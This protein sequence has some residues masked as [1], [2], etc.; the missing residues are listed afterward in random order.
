MGRVGA[1]HGIRGAFRVRPE[2]ADPAALL[3]YAEWLLRLRGGGW[4]PRRVRGARAQGGGL[5]AELEGIES[6]EAAGALRGAE[7]GIARESLPAL[8]EDEYYQADLIGLAVV[9]REGVMLGAVRD[10]VESGAH[11]IARVVADDGAE[12]LIPW[13]APRIDR[14]D[15][16]ARRIDVDWPADA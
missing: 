5:V 14:V 16:A 8:A 9:N 4:S 10:F 7:I 15:V 1:P 11:P 6:R 12:R 13:V 3:G 2:S